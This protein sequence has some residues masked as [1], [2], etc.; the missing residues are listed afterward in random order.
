MLGRLVARIVRRRGNSRAARRGRCEP[1]LEA[2]RDAGDRRQP[3]TAAFGEDR[4]DPHRARGAGLDEEAIVGREWRRVG[5]L[6]GT[7][8]NRIEQRQWLRDPFNAV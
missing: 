4:L 3:S 2:I 8:Y 1:F 5:R 6:D 7:R